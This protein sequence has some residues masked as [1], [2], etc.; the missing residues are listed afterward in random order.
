M[1][2]NLKFSKKKKGILI[3]VAIALFV[4]LVTVIVLV[5]MNGTKDKTVI[6]NADS[7]EIQGEERLKFNGVSVISD[8]QRIMADKTLGEIKDVKVKDGQEVQAGDILF[9]YHNT[10][11]EEQAAQFDRQISGNN[12][13]ATRV[14]NDKSKC[15]GSI[16]E[17]QVQLNKIVSELDT[18]KSALAQVNASG[19]QGEQAKYGELTQKQAA[20]ESSKMEVSQK[21]EV[22]KGQISGLDTEVAAFDDTNKGIVAERDILNKKVSVEVAAELDGI[23]KIDDKGLNDPTAVYMRV[24]SKEPLIKAEVSEFDLSNL[25]INDDVLLRVVSSGEYVKGTITKIDELPIE[26]VGRTTTGY[27]FYI[28]PEK[29]ITIGFSLEVNYNYKGIQIP[30]DYVYEEDS[31]IH[32]LKENGTS[33]D[34][35]EIKAIS[36]GDSYYL[37]DGVVGIGDR[38]IKNPSKVL[39]GSK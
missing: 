31:K 1:K 37:L 29:S 10:T 11:L 16:N 19:D 28:K 25:K 4:I 20:L 18:V 7:Y 33:Y 35:V 22:L 39:E 27:N 3:A 5:K 17:L 8:E 30:K 12:E 6:A 36:E 21:I 32:V 2:L 14:K 38:L 34:N 13:K 26:G 9:S 24:I 15:N 23:V